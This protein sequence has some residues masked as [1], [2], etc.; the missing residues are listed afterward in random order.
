MSGHVVFMHPACDFHFFVVW[1]NLFLSWHG[2]A[3]LGWLVGET[4]R[5]PSE[6]KRSAIESVGCQPEASWK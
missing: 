1:D 6:R 3:S 2:I 4:M 5:G